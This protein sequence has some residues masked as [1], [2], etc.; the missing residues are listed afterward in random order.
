MKLLE[1]KINS[2]FRNLKGLRI[3]FDSKMST[4]VVIGT[5]G[6]GKSNVLEALSSV[7]K[8]LYYD[9]NRNFEFD[10]YLKYE[11]LNHDILL[12]YNDDS[13]KFVFKIDNT[14]VEDAEMEDILAQYLPSRIICN[15]SGEDS[16]IYESYYKEP[17]E[18]YT[19][20]L[21]KGMAAHSLQMMFVNKD[22][23]KIIFVVMACCKD[24]V[25][26]FANF[27]TT[28]LGVN[29]IDHIILHV[30]EKELDGWS[31]SAPA[32]YLRQLLARTA[33]RDISID[34]FCPNGEDALFVYNN[35]VGVYELIKED[36]VITFN[37]G[38]DTAFFSEGEK[39]MMVVLFM[40]EALSDER[41]LLLLDEPDSHIH[42][43]QKGKLVSFLTETDNRENVITTHSPS[44]TTQFDDEAIIMLSADVNGNA[45]V[46][47]KD[48]AAIVKILTNDTWTIQQQNIFLNSNKD[49][50]L[51]EGWTDEAYISK[52]LE[53]FHKQGKY[54]DLDFSYL[55][56]N[57][58][59]NVKIM[60][61]KFH[62]KKNQMMIALFDN[63]GAGWKSIRDVFNLDKDANKKAFGKAQKKAD[64]WYAL[65][66]VPAGRRGDIN[67]EDYFHHNVLSKFVMSFKTLN[68]IVEKNSLKSKLA[69]MCNKN[70][71][72]DIKFSK[73]AKLFN[74]IEEIKQ[75]DFDSKTKI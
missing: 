11:I 57:G 19:K 4:Y 3:K 53:V 37:N 14:E 40:L 59:S 22:Y 54:M 38:I 8:T 5:N 35:L 63:D 68:E 72:A 73:F 18:H 47:D 48:K 27:L 28:T 61:E 65:I 62:P 74:F 30:D 36:F 6:A 23:W 34:D 56:C 25:E 44:L 32:L 66:P 71:L 26:A 29:V 16:R 24:Q 7:F 17:R 21:I 43:A 52:A 42:V 46:V 51:V 9:S 70:E 39:K 1:F 55:P 49:I 58:S 64:I 15:Y 67:I 12:I 75:A 20:E 13:H 31:N 41:S 69:E 10:F 45:E 50:L 2:S 60:S 33:G